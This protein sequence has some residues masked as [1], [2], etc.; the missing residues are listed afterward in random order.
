MGE[1]DSEMSALEAALRQILESD[2]ETEAALDARWRERDAAEKARRA[3][4]RGLGFSKT[5]L[6]VLTYHVPD[7]ESLIRMTPEQVGDLSGCG[8]NAFNAI[9]AFIEAREPGR[10]FRLNP[11]PPPPTPAQRTAMEQMATHLRKYGWTV[12]PPSQE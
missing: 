10:V 12:T 8:P 1:M 7:V 2:P 4:W 5:A 6:G 11:T 3:Y 9:A